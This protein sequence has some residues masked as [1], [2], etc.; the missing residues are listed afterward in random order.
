MK[1]LINPVSKRYLD[2][3][4]ANPPHGLL[5]EGPD[6]IGKGALSRHIAGRILGIDS[7]KTQD[8]PYIRIIE[9][10]GSISIDDIRKLTNFTKL[11]VSGKQALKRVI[12]VE[13]AGNMTREAQNAFLKLLEEPPADT[14]II[15]SAG[16]KAQLLPT[17]VS[18]VV[19]IAVTKPTESDIKQHFLGMGYKQ[20]DVDRALAISGGLPGLMTAL[21][22]KD[23][24]DALLAYIDNS[25]GLLGLTTFERL[26]KADEY[27]KQKDD[28][29]LLLDALDK[30]ARA[31][32][33][34][35]INSG[36]NAQTVRWN[37]LLAEISGKQKA[38]G[39]NPNTKLLLTDLVLNL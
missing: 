20:I 15:L 18:R 6:G 27:I 39:S 34:S 24:E 13:H 26:I 8:H 23:E 16:N 33:N 11:K 2:G 22:D 5:L 4:S 9:Q 25:K 10:S 29:A 30:V 17:I 31:A 12:I 14:V 37:N 28:V 35:A 32:L 36:K 38:L 21:L 3:I 1:L 7:E 19:A